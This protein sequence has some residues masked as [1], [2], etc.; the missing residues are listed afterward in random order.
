[1]NYLQTDPGLTLRLGSTAMAAGDDAA[2]SLAEI[3]SFGSNGG[4]ALAADDADF[5]YLTN[6]VDF[7]IEG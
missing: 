2:V 5:S 7:T 3:A 1:M 4:P 6:A